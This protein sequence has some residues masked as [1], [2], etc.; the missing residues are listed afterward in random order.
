MISLQTISQK[1]LADQKYWITFVGDS[2]TSCEWV[3]PNWR[4]IVEYVLKQEVGKI[5]Q[6]DWKVPSW[7]IRG[8]NCGY[9][10][11]TTQDILTNI[12]NITM[13]QPDLV[14]VVMGGNDRLAHISVAQHIKN[15]QRIIHKLKTNVIWCTSTPAIEPRKMTEYAPYAQACMA[16]LQKENDLSID[17]FT[18]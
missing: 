9:D 3:H 2:I 1:L 12:K 7:D 8:F 18:L 6:G 17:L 4:E 14:I 15:I 11:S 16:A 5:W 13:T 10:G